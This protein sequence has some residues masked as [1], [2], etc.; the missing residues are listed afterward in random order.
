MTPVFTIILSVGF[1]QKSYSGMTYLSL[2]PVSVHFILRGLQF[3]SRMLCMHA[4]AIGMQ[5]L[6]MLT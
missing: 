2:L 6:T 5:F 4:M 1:L 3:H